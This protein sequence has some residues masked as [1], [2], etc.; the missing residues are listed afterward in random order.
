MRL[1]LICL[2]SL[3][4]LNTGCGRRG[5]RGKAD[6]GPKV[7]AVT[8]A[9]E[10]EAEL[11]LV[12]PGPGD[13]PWWR[14][15]SRN[16]ISVSQTAPL[17]WSPT[18]N[19]VW[20][21]AVPGRGHSSPTI[22]GNRIFL[23]TADEAAKE[24]RLLAYDRTTGQQLWNSLC[25]QGGLDHAHDKNTHASATP[26]CD[27]ERVY[28][29]FLSAGAI[30]LTATDLEGKQ[31]YQKRV[32]PFASQH[33]FAASPAIWGSL[34]IASGESTAGGFLCAY[35]RVTGDLI[36]SAEKPSSASYSSPIVAE[37]S[38]R[39]QVLLSGGNMVGSYSAITGETLWTYQGGPSTVTSGTAAFANDRVF[40]S[41]GYPE[42][43]TL[44]LPSNANGAVSSSQLL[45]QNKQKFYVPSLLAV[46]DTLYGVDDGGV[47][48]CYDA[49]TGQE[50]WKH[51]L[52][53]GF[54]SSP[55]L[56]GDKLYAINEGGTTY[57]FKAGPKFEQLAANE[58]AEG[59]F[60]TPACVN[61]QLFIRTNHDLWCIGSA[62]SAPTAETSGGQ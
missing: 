51:R 13:W 59:G 20:K 2:L 62:T 53:G 23:A 8:K 34:V 12:Q 38:G 19:I 25:H 45:W 40:V 11:P 54:S 46:D 56:V 10:K 29:T 7:S 27:G 43:Q 31:V 3:T 5:P 4:F 28:I 41:G 37:L 32:G 49:K 1:L 33:G 22:W 39:P 14:G 60:A 15:P 35:H 44:C 58:L 16:G 9:V 61:G 24:H 42:A 47:A 30:W 18:E 57:V 26:A 21:A 55:I 6:S 50:R 52:G 36:W 48:Y 17:S